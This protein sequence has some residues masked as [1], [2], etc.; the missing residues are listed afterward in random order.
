MKSMP[1]QSAPA[2]HSTALWWRLGGC[3]C[4]WFRTRAASVRAYLIASRKLRAAP[5]ARSWVSCVWPRPAVLFIGAS[6]GS[7]SLNAGGSFAYTPVAGYNGADSCF[8]RAIDSHGSLSNLVVV[9]ITVI[10]PG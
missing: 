1:P 3:V 4:Y 8:Y 5:C 10:A 9:S 7:V 6:R 2:C